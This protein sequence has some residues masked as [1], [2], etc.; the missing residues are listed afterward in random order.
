VNGVE[1]E[2]DD[3]CRIGTAAGAT[4]D[5]HIYH[6]A[7]SETCYDPRQREREIFHDAA[8]SIMLPFPV[9]G[10]T[11]HVMLALFFCK[12]GA[13]CCPRTIH[14]HLMPSRWPLMHLGMARAPRQQAR[15]RNFP[16]ISGGYKWA[17]LPSGSWVSMILIDGHQQVLLPAHCPAGCCSCAGS[18]GSPSQLCSRQ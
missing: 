6:I 1:V 12:L 5:G 4:E 16:C 15:I 17:Y 3:E 9:S 7:D 8:L 14:S 11:G 10:I 18:K 2:V 13:V